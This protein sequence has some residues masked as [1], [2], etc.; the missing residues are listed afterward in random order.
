MKRKKIY[1]L[2]NRGYSPYFQFYIGW[3]NEARKR[4]ISIYLLST[5]SFK[6]FFTKLTILKKDGLI[7]IPCFSLFDNFIIKSFLFL[8]ILLNE[9]II[10]QLK[11]REPKLLNKLK[12]FFPKKLSCIIDCEGDLRSEYDYL[13]TH[14][15]KMNFYKQF[16]IN[17][18]EKIKTYKNELIKAD[19]IIC[20]TKNLKNLFVSRD[21]INENKI[22]ALTTGCDSELFHYD[23]IMREKY[24]KLLGLDSK[25]VLIYIGNLHYSWQNIS[26]T[27]K[28]YKIIKEIEKN[29]KLIIITMKSDFNILKNFLNKYKIKQNEIIIKLSVPNDQIP[30]YL[31]ASD[32]GMI[33][34]EDHLMNNVAAPGKFGEYACCGLPILTGKGIADFSEKLSKTSYGIVLDD[35]YNDQEFRMKFKQFMNGYDKI[36]RIKISK[37]GVKHF[38]YTNFSDDYVN[39]LVSIMEKKR[40]ENS[41]NH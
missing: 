11:K 10:V 40:I 1:Y 14:P 31:N 28:I 3:V 18:D 25:F 37:W 5:I 19:H 6:E 30:K 12:L 16:L 22:T 4:G 17:K 15:Y 13:S 21:K 38:S 32:L 41:K 29:A 9:K 27:L 36:D 39:L 7:F 35:I 24:R 23:M 34:R 8:Q 26:R 2:C 20:V 33:L